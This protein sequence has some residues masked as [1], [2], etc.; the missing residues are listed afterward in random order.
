VKKKIIAVSI[1]VVI[2]AVVLVVTQLP[3]DNPSPDYVVGIWNNADF[4]KPAE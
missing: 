2:I 1:A 4:S 3:K